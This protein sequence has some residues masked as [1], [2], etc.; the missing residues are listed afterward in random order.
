MASNIQIHKCAEQLRACWQLTA[1]C[2]RPSDARIA[3]AA[4][5]FIGVLFFA[6]LHVLKPRALVRIPAGS[7]GVGTTTTLLP[8]PALPD[9][10]ARNPDAKSAIVAPRSTGPPLCYPLS[11]HNSYTRAEIH[12]IRGRTKNNPA[13]LWSRAP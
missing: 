3:T 7:V 9:S 11:P 6:A 1:T 13:A 8:A 12:G 10:R 5:P 2:A 4:S